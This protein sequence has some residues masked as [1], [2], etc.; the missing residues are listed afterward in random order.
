M[1]FK[2]DNY[3][4]STL[5]NCTIHLTKDELIEYADEHL[6][7]YINEFLPDGITF[8]SIEQGFQALRVK[9]IDE[10]INICGEQNG[11]NAKVNSKTYKNRP[12]WSVYKLGLMKF[13]TELK[14]V[15]HL[16]LA[17]KLAG[18]EETIHYDI[19]YID[20]YWGR[21]K[22]GTIR[23]QDNLGAILN[24]RRK[25][26]REVFHLDVVGFKGQKSTNGSNV[27]K[28]I[29]LQTQLEQFMEDIKG[30]Y[31]YVIDTETSGLSPRFWDIIELSA[32][33][34]NGDTFEIEDEFDE[35]INPGYNLPPEIVKFNEKNGTGICDELLQTKGLLPK[36]ALSRFKEFV[37]ENPNI[38]GQNIKFDISF[39]EKLYKK[40]SKTEFV[41]NECIDTLAMAKEKIPGKHNLE[42]LFGMIPNAPE[43]SFHKSIDDVK[44]TF[45]VFK[46]LI[47]SEYLIDINMTNDLVLE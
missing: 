19:S 38:M 21:V 2:G 29:H 6:H 30:K 22:D 39:I 10:F 42:V 37:G 23:S 24:E 33:K 12:K 13:L 4:L 16:D 5:Y 27:S 26:Y 3:F 25:Y 15:Q 40:Q 1:Y 18:I 44:A 17:R 34:V 43:L 31:F 8:N 32:I 7:D 47:S 28:T 20:Y 11:Y 36:E 35:F 45:E 46:W 41:Y 14:F 9:N